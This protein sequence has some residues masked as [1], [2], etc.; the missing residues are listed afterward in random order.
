MSTRPI[1]AHL[2]VDLV[3][4]LDHYAERLERSRGWVVEKALREWIRREEYRDRLTREALDE[5]DRGEWVENERVE[6][7]LDSLGSPDPKPR[8]LP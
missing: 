8:P 6:E 5:V 7:W 3:E 1:T 4:G 2:P